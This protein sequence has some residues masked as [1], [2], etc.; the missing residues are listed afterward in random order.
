ML[1]TAELRPAASL[2]WGRR[3]VDLG[4]GGADRPP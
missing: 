3:L 1:F 4:P 2:L